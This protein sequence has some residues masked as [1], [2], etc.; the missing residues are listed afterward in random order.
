MTIGYTTSLFLPLW[1]A[2][3]SD[4]RKR[5]NQE[6]APIDPQT[7]ARAAE[8]GIAVLSSS[9]STWAVVTALAALGVSAGE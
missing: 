1:E 9:Q 3:A 8:E 6:N 7:L 4:H 2:I 5:Q